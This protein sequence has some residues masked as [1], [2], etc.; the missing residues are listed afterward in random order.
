MLYPKTNPR[1]IDIKIDR[2]AKKVHDYLLSAWGIDSSSYFCFGRVYRN[3]DS[4]GRYIPEAYKGKKEYSDPLYNDKSICTSFFGVDTDMQSLGGGDFTAQCHLIFSLNIAKI[5]TDIAHRADE[6]IHIDCLNALRSGLDWD[7]ITE[8]VTGLNVV[9]AEY[10]GFK[11]QDGVIFTDMHP[12]H[13][14]RIN[15]DLT[16]NNTNC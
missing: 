10:N 13:V 5:K 7:S 12:K 11:S 2:I 14:F 15:F 16:F 4:Q 9:F 1:G 8:I 6:E 3:Q